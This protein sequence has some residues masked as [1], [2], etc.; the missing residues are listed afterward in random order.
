MNSRTLFLIAVISTAL[1]V[2]LL[3]AIRVHLENS[4][5]RGLKVNLYNEHDKEPYSNDLGP[6]SRWD[7]EISGSLKDIWWS[8]DNG[9]SW[10]GSQLNALSM[11]QDAYWHIDGNLLLIAGSQQDANRAGDIISGIL[12]AGVVPAMM[13]GANK[14]PF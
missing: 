10:H 6:Y 5:N 12:T 8:T 3:Q 1:S 2:N 4:S 14:N 13:H 11:A 7:K 9:K